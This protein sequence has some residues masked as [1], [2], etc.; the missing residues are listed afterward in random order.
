[1]RLNELKS[2]IKKEIKNLQL[3]EQV[4]PQGCMLNPQDVVNG[5]YPNSFQSGVWVSKFENLF[6]TRLQNQGQT[7]ACQMYYA[8]KDSWETTL[9]NLHAKPFPKCNKKWQGM[10]QFKI[11]EGD[12]IAVGC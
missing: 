2:I 9:S 4:L 6:S 1:M 5:P 10:L 12:M 8:K 3:N 7:S 11:R